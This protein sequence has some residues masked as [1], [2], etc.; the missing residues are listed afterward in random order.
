MGLPLASFRASESEDLTTT[1]E[2]MGSKDA[3]LFGSS[4]VNLCQMII[5]VYNVL[6]GQ[7]DAYLA[8]L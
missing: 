8:V 5:L 3:S 1:H 2:A 7:A 6:F 4:K